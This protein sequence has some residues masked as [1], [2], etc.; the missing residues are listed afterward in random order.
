M[1]NFSLEEYCG[2]CFSYSFEIYSG[3]YS[4][5]LLM[6]R[7]RI[8]S[9]TSRSENQA[10]STSSFNNHPS[11]CFCSIFIADWSLS[12]DCANRLSKVSLFFHRPA[13]SW[14]IPCTFEWC[15]DS[16]SLALK[17]GG[18]SLARCRFALMMCFV[19]R[20][21]WSVTCSTRPSRPPSILG[22]CSHL[23]D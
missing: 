11:H 19:G 12:P 4:G 9:L 20:G 15:L 1:I 13:D 3:S 5:L 8:G 21:G 17:V 23:I 2:F 6:D 14:G 22:M 7:L 18:V 10:T 16:S